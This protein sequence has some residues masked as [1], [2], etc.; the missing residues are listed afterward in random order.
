MRISDTV[1][2]TNLSRLRVKKGISQIEL[3]RRTG[4]SRSTINKLEHRD[5]IIENCSLLTLCKLMKN[6]DCSLTDLLEDEEA[7]RFFKKNI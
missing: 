6:L 1:S 3:C 2:K 4:L 5:L 7:I